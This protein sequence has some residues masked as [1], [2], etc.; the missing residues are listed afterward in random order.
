MVDNKRKRQYKTN[1]FLV[2]GK[3]NNRTAITEAKGEAKTD[4]TKGNTRFINWIFIKYPM[5]ANDDYTLRC[6]WIS[7]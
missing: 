1:S 6:S 2:V 5:K 7:Q 3:R 4:L